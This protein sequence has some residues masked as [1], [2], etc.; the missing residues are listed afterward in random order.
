MREE[1]ALW[2]TVCG[3]ATQSLFE[4]VGGCATLPH[5]TAS[6]RQRGAGAGGAR[7]GTEHVR[8]DGVTCCD[9]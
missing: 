7:L 1:C 2:Q 6:L 3:V 4:E 9:S 5:A 8:G